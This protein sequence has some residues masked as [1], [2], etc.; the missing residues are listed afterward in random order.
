[1]VVQPS[2]DFS[3]GKSG[4]ALNIW[5]SFSFVNRE[6]NEID[7]TLSYT[8]KTAKNVLLKAGLIHYGYY[9]TENFSFDDNTSHELFISAGLPNTITHP[10]LT[11]F[12][13]FTNG[14]GFYFQLETGHSIPLTPSAKADFSASLGY[15]GGQWLAE[16]VDPGFSD[17]NIGMAAS[18]EFRDWIITPYANYTFVL[19]EALGNDDYF[20][21]GI[22]VDYSKT[23]SN[24]PN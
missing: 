23:S 10:T 13:D 9:F 3:F 18:I 8:F 12:Y 11:V 20:W 7:L 1:M 4:L 17:L 22:K 19:L 6:A 14:D 15:N 2:A 16:G 24:A 5:S 21:F